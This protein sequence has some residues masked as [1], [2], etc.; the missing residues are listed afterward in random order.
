MG[1]GDG[2]EGKGDGMKES[3]GGQSILGVRRPTGEQQ[4]PDLSTNSSRNNCQDCICCQ[5]YYN[6]NNG[7]HGTRTR[8]KLS[9]QGYICKFFHL[10]GKGEGWGSGIQGLPSKKNTTWCPNEW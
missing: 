5:L 6:S 10:R 3:G 8:K 1:W 7:H 9:I 4:S 2:K